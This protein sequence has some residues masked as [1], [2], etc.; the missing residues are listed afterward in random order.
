VTW[1]DKCVDILLIEMKCSPFILVN[2]CFYRPM[3]V[4]R[5]RTSSSIHIFHLVDN[6]MHWPH[7]RAKIVYYENDTPFNLQIKTS[8]FQL[9][10]SLLK[11]NDIQLQASLNFIT[12]SPKYM[13]GGWSP[14]STYF[15]GSIK[16]CI[17]QYKRTT[18]H[19]LYCNII[20]FKS[21][22]L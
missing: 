12:K 8:Y 16:T 14:R 19:L 3:K 6:N 17:D 15:H 18:F 5:P 10:S 21:C 4:C 13:D 1:I 11:V 2:T 20:L 9:I 7:K 22:D